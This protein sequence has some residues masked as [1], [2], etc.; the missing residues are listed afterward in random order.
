MLYDKAP[1]RPL[2]LHSQVQFCKMPWKQ[3]AALLRSSMCGLSLMQV[4][5][6]FATG[7]SWGA[8]EPWDWLSLETCGVS[9]L[10]LRMAQG[11]HP[12]PHPA[13]EPWLSFSWSTW[14]CTLLL[15]MACH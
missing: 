5:P 6:A 8:K 11:E 2:P 3:L 14:G 9:G 7:E 4:S 13:G 15:M 1:C 10:K 12:I